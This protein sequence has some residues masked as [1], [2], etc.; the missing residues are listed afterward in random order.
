MELDARSFVAASLPPQVDDPKKRTPGHDSQSPDSVEARPVG[1]KD[2]GGQR[3]A[4]HPKSAT[5]PA[6]QSSLSQSCEGIS[7]IWLS[8]A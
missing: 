4:S 8:R 6:F 1:A 3:S 5:S 2:L 7:V